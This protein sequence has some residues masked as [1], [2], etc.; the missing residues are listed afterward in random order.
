MFNGTVYQQTDGLLM[1]SPLASLLANWFVS[2]LETNLLNKT[3]NPKMYCRYVDD[4]F[5]IFENKEEAHLF[6]KEL[7]SMYKDMKFVIQTCQDRKLPFLDTQVA[8]KNN[9]IITTS[10]RKPSSTGVLMN[11]SSCV[12]QSWKRSLVKNLYYRNQH[13][14]SEDQH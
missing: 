8:I 1:G 10:Y 2:Q 7:N 5:C 12:P 6:E 4:I 11:Y 9:T 3:K 13:L 14:V